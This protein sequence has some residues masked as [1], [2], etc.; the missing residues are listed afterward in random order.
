MI[1][2]AVSHYEILDRIG[3]GGMGVVYRARDTRL[4]RTVA[5]K[6]LPEE[7]TRDEKARRR[8][9]HEARAAA[10]LDH[11]NICTV[12][13]VGESDDD[14]IWIAMACY[15]GETLKSV[16]EKGVTSVEMSIR[17]ARQ[18]ADGLSKAHA[19][20]IVHR[21]IKPENVIITSDGV[22]KILDFGL[23][24]S[25]NTAT[26]TNPGTLLGTIA[27]MSPEQ[28]KGDNVAAPTDV[29]SLGV[30]LYE[31]L[32]GNRPFR[33]DY[34]QAV[35][36]SILSE[37]HVPLGEMR[38]D[39][40]VDLV[41]IVERM[42]E[43][44]PAS[45]YAHC[46]EVVADLDTLIEDGS[47]SQ[48]VLLTRPR[49][50]GV[51]GRRMVRAAFL[52][53]VVIVAV[54]TGLK[55][56]ESPP[57]P[58]VVAM[59]DNIVLG[60]LPFQ[61]ISVEPLAPM[62]GEGFAQAL[63]AGLMN[64]PSVQVASIFEVDGTESV[65]ELM[66]RSGANLMLRGTLQ[67]SGE[68]L[69]VSWTIVDSTGL[70]LGGQSAEGPPEEIF[71]IQNRVNEQVLAS[72]R[73]PAKATALIVPDDGHFKQ[74]LYLQALGHLTRY[75]DQAAVDRAIALL[76]K[77]GD[78]A[79]VQ[80]ALGRAY[81]RKYAI[82]GDQEWAERAESATFGAADLAPEAADVHWT[83][84]ELYLTT[85][86]PDRAETE[87]R[88]V[89]EAW[90]NDVEALTGLATALDKQGRD[91]EAEAAYKDAVAARPAYWSVHNK[92]GTFYLIRGRFDE[93]LA[94]FTEAES[95][96]PDNVFVLNNMAVTYQQS[97]DYERAIEVYERSARVR[98]DGDTFS[99]LGTLL[100]FVG[101][102][103]DAV[104][105][106]ERS[107][108]MKP[109]QAVYWAGLGD[110]LRWTEGR[111][112]EATA[113]YR[114][115]IDLYRRDLTVRPRDP[116]TL[117]QL[118]N[119]QAKSGAFADAASTAEL[120]VSLL[121]NHPAICYYAGSALEVAGRHDRALTL[122]TQA[123]ESGYSLEEARHD[124]EIRKLNEATGL[125]SKYEGGKS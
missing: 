116:V 112:D 107:T 5:L 2:T 21:D 102:F 4:G 67:R 33:G 13:D 66:R 103:G 16:I 22:A 71:G 34:L 52:A 40:P 3:V 38:P 53:V 121:P 89:L 45:R 105:M 55:L 28:L 43:K 19:S 95:L 69:R 96:T 85:A 31:M 23:A 59:P 108:A 87:F 54:V 80:A 37:R 20:G 65:A 39:L 26:L 117:V 70:Q 110:A 61:D 93:A 12:Y 83:L 123:L 114:K 84:G 111:R 9:L 11:P 6:F 98:P 124:P 30:L 75:E 24:K 10:K 99:N 119:C 1:P 86:K 62:L 57:T 90:P 60:V 41:R 27:Y 113:A 49:P 91:E 120:A 35:A 92:L 109:N 78:S 100:F 56:N 44:N 88:A 50:N 64:A 115:A 8:F 14:Q 63:S 76:E 36:Y 47:G 58:P 79:E 81:L 42:L 122:I 25:V 73:H 94:R 32:A 125:L 17:I 29:W 97:G 48:G 7:L 101:R 77:L 18:L 15:D 72:L 46:E 68:T 104:D 82:V 106:F 118:A 74:D 51:K